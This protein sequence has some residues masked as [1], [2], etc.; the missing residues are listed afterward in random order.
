MELCNITSDI[1]AGCLTDSRRRAMVEEDEARRRLVTRDEEG[2][3]EAGPPCRRGSRRV[4]HLLLL[5]A[6]ALLVCLGRRAGEDGHEG[7][8][9][10]GARPWQAQ[11]DRLLDL[12]IIE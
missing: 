9:F 2:E 5:V 11:A 6:A 4:A 10:E 3:E 12:A 8:G 7:A 1:L